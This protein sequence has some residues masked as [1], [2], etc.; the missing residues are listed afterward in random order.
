MNLK[1]NSDAITS[2]S[3]YEEGTLTSQFTLSN[4]S[5]LYKI[6][7]VVFFTVY[8]SSSSQ[9]TVSNVTPLAQFPVGFR[10]KK[11]TYATGQ[12]FISSASDSFTTSYMMINK[13]G[14]LLEG[15][16]NSVTFKYLVVSG[17]FVCDE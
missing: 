4:D 9:T 12:W 16:A 7:R 1:S 8:L 2:L 17:S 11:T 15:W 3:A 13:N 6:G 14:E 10:P 5:Y